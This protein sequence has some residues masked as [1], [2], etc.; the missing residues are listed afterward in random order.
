MQQI[1]EQA[2]RTLSWQQVLSALPESRLQRLEAADTWDVQV[3][4]ETLSLL[5]TTF[6]LSEQ[7]EVSARDA[8]DSPLRNESVYL[9][10]KHA[11][12]YGLQHL[13]SDNAQGEQYLTD[14]IGAILGAERRGVPFSR[15]SGQHR[16]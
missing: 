13:T 9:L 1:S 5:P 7:E 10:R 15:G 8:W 2:G 6:P 14:A 11:L 3:L 16:S 12:A 4:Q